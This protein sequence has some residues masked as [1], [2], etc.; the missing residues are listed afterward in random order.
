MLMAYRPMSQML[1]FYVVP[2]IDARVAAGRLK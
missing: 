2:E 1:R